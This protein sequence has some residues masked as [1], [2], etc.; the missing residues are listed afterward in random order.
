MLPAAKI[1]GSFV[2][3]SVSM[4]SWP[5]NM[6]P[7]LQIAK[8]I[9]MLMVFSRKFRKASQSNVLVLP[10]SRITIA[11]IIFPCGKLFTCQSINSQPTSTSILFFEIDFI[12]SAYTFDSHM[13]LY[14]LSNMFFKFLYKRTKLHRDS[15]NAWFKRY[16]DIN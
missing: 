7:D 3:N 6:S 13:F 12:T 8:N 2:L 9:L 5:S 11:F 4:T 14:I 10:L 15:K 16:S 1:D